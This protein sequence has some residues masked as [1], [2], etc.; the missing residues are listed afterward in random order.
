MSQ[1]DVIQFLENEL[2]SAQIEFST[3]TGEMLAA[4]DKK[5]KAGGW[6]DARERCKHRIARL[7]GFLAAIRPA[8][9][10]AQS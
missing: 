9:Q 3:L 8:S 7:E 10:G 6:R 1:P 5:A 4:Q 2:H